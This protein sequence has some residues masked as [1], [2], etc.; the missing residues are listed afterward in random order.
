MQQN[1]T[2]NFLRWVLFFDAAT[3][4]ATGLLM[5]LV[6]GLLERYLGLPAALLRSAGISLLPFAAFLIYLGKREQLAPPVVWAVI[7]LNALWTLDSMLLLVSG[8]VAPTAFGYAFVIFQAVGVAVFAG[9]EYFGLRR[10]ILKAGR[11]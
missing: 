3:C 8:W 2:S 9:L 4:I 11:I 6:S 10:D 1:R 7:V 5:M